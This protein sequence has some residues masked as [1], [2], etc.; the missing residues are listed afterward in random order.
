MQELLVKLLYLETQWRFPL[1]EFVES[2]EDWITSIFYNQFRAISVFLN[3]ILDGINEALLVIPPLIFILAIFIIAWR[4]RGVSLGIFVVLSLL[5]MNNMGYWDQVIL[6]LAMVTTSVI[7]SLSI[8]IP[9]GIISAHIPIIYKIIRP[10]LDFMQTIPAY[11][12]LL[13][14]IVLFG[15]GTVPGIIATTIFA[16][17]PPIRATYLGITEVPRERVEAG[18]AFGASRWQMLKEIE[19]PSA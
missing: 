15:L 3:I 17:P 1:G 5:L 11:V 12:Y 9:L 7:I 8:G 4:L 16:V 14:A 13:P 18:E 19:L 6:T 10:I 2:F